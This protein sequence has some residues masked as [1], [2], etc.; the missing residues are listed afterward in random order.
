MDEKKLKNAPSLVVAYENGEIF[1]IPEFAMAGRT[2]YDFAIPA[3]EE[4]IPMPE[5]SELYHLPQRVAVG[6]DRE[7]GK[8][9]VVETWESKP[10]FPVAVFVAPA[11]MLLRLAGFLR[12][13]EAES[14]P[15]FMYGA[16]GWQGD[17]F[18]ISAQRVDD[19]I[20]QDA[21]QFDAMEL[22]RRA[23]QVLQA[24]PQNR[25][26]EHLVENCYRRY[27]CPA[28]RNF[29]MQRWEMPLPTAMT[30]NSR[31]AG[32]ISRIRKG[33]PRPPQD[34]IAFTPTAEEIAEI[35]VPH[36]QR[37]PRAIASFGQGC[38]GEPLMN[39][40][41]LEEAI[42]RIRKRTSRGTINLN[43]NGSKPDV[44]ERLFK[45]GLDSIRVSMNSVIP[46]L[47]TA[48]FEP[49]DYTYDDVI[50]TLSRA[51]RL[52]K[53][54]SINYFVFPGI[55]DRE[56]EYRALCSVIDDTDIDMI[57]WRN[58]TIDPDD[59]LSLLGERLPGGTSNTL[60]M[61]T[62]LSE[63]SS[64]YPGLRFGYYNPPLDQ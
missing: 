37:A 3:D 16:V 59:Y 47:Y 44:V 42:V 15:L 35:A 49:V 27:W 39:P 57:Q 50:E 45:A 51:R 48:Y 22:D 21:D 61:K 4:M 9:C 17:G 62:A 18:V 5:G 60:G 6:F 11:Y 10:V 46:E 52:E 23:Q 12:T 64:R 19:D 54:A 40:A 20:R 26:A 38:E 25:L 14:L 24:Y 36:L 31:C 58:F 55:T 53:F 43:T 7:T 1:D 41:L 28:A 8:S 32:C 63:L 34:R 29:L 33:K 56:E 13:T 30:C 2:G